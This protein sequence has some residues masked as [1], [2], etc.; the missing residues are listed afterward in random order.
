MN[1]D[2]EGLPTEREQIAFAKNLADSAETYH[3]WLMVI[4]FGLPQLMRNQRFL[5]KLIDDRV[6]KDSEGD[7]NL[8]HS[9]LT[10][11]NDIGIKLEINTEGVE[12]C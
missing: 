3:I 5:M 9:F 6:K 1:D 8:N 12:E 10:V 7:N 4:R 11:M 2:G